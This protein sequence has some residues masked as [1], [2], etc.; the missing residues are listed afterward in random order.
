MSPADDLRALVMVHAHALRRLPHPTQPELT[1]LDFARHH[2]S[3]PN[4]PEMTRK[5]INV[6]R[7]ALN[8][9]VARGRPVVRA[10]NVRVSRRMWRL[11]G[12]VADV[13]G[14]SVPA[15]VR[16]LVGALEPVRGADDDEP[17]PKTLRVPLDVVEHHGSPA[18]VRRALLSLMTQHERA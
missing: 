12:D 10:V 1:A 5:A 17:K 14:V 3:K 8:L 13:A 4:K 15:A 7:R 9:E 16:R 2:M 18:G 11:V 6:L